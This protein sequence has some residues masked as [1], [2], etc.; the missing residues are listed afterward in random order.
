MP[1]ITPSVL[2]IS[3]S[4][5]VIPPP[6]TSASFPLA[7]PS[8]SSEHTDSTTDPVSD[9]DQW[10]SAGDADVDGVAGNFTK[11]A[12]KLGKD[13][14]DNWILLGRLAEREHGKQKRRTNSTKCENVRVRT[15]QGNPKSIL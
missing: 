3:P 2:V 7:T 1:V 9:G 5:P 12:E 6:L 8:G 14:E 11:G 15:G 4:V 13:S 10:Q